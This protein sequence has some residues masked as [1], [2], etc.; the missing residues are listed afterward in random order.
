M[1]Y[2]MVW[3]IL[4]AF[5]GQD[6]GYYFAADPTQLQSF[7]TFQNWVGTITSFIRFAGNP[8]AE[9]LN[10]DVNMALP[11]WG[12][13]NEKEKHFNVTDANVSVP[14]LESADAKQM[15]RCA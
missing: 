9:R 3:D 1:A 10:A 14:F 6:A 13:I 15:A 11:R 7:T 2:K 4:P 5:H 8:N 12:H